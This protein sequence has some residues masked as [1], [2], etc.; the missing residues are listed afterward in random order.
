MC[1]YQLIIIGYILF[2]CNFHQGGPLHIVILF[3]FPV[4]AC[5][6]APLNLD[7]NTVSLLLLISLNTLHYLL[8]MSLNLSPPLE[9]IHLLN[10][11]QIT[12]FEWSIYFL[13]CHSVENGFLI[14]LSL[15]IILLSTVNINSC[16][17]CCNS[18]LLVSLLLP[19]FC[20]ILSST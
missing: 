13:I 7:G 1:L 14:F 17:F 15:G 3:N 8:I 16:L 19:L 18:L 10:F 2:G 9:I 5:P 11:P 6:M 12:L 4:V 20:Y